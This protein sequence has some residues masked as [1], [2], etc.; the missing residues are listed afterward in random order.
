MRL[1]W[2]IQFLEIILNALQRRLPLQI[3]C[4]RRLC[5]MDLK[6]L[7][8]AVQLQK[9]RALNDWEIVSQTY[10]AEAAKLAALDREIARPFDKALT[11]LPATRHL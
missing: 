7:H 11:Q 9:M 10:R 4:V 3:V 6:H 8:K 2:A 5:K 1:K